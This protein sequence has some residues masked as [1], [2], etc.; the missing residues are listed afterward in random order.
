MNGQSRQIA[1]L[2]A[3][4]VQVWHHKV[5]WNLVEGVKIYKVVREPWWL[6]LELHWR[7]QLA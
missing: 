5:K 2:A 1:D 4:T 7:R 6:T 3:L